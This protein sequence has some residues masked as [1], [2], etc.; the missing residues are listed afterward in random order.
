MQ[1]IRQLVAYNIRRLRNAAGI[2]QEELAAAADM[3]RGYLANLELGK[4]YYASTRTLDKLAKAL[5]VGITEF[6]ASP[7]SKSVRR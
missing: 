1:E 6:F 3:N 4:R 5:N 2:S 7:P